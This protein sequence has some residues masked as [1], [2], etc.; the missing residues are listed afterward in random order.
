MNPVQKG[1]GLMVEENKA[2]LK[3]RTGVKID[4]GAAVDAVPPRPRPSQITEKA[5]VADARQAGFSTRADPVKIDGR[6]LR[7][8]D[9]VTQMNIKL[10][11]AVREAFQSCL[12]NYISEEKKRTTEDFIEYLLH[13]YQTRGK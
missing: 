7:R 11:P 9:R 3:P 13:L 2:D 8:T 5:A 4:F 6:S 1:R 10:T 12:V